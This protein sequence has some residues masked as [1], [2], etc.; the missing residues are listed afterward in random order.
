MMYVVH[1]LTEGTPEERLKKVFYALNEGE[2]F[3]SQIAALATMDQ[4]N[5]FRLEGLTD[6]EYTAGTFSLWGVS[7]LKYDGLVTTYSN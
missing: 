2:W 1:I 5:A 7:K 3:S 4:Y 6:E